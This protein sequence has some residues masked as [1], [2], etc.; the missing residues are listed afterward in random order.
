L[1]LNVQGVVLYLILSKEKCVSTYAVIASP[2]AL[3]LEEVADA[4]LANG[5]ELVYDEPVETYR[6]QDISMWIIVNANKLVEE[7]EHYNAYLVEGPK[8]EFPTLGFHRVP[9]LTSLRYTS[10]WYKGIVERVCQT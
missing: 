9:L 4:L 10:K 5:Y 6:P 7:F 8:H 3:S 1:E 2:K